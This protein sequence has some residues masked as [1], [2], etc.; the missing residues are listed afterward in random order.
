MTHLWITISDSF[1]GSIQILTL[2]SFLDQG[3]NTS[4]GNI[5]IVIIF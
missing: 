1:I 4:L 3:D 5:K 2:I